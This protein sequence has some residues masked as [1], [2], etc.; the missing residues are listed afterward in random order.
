MAKLDADNPFSRRSIGKITTNEGYNNSVI[1]AAQMNI[2]IMNSPYRSPFISSILVGG[3]TNLK[4]IFSSHNLHAY[5]GLVMEKYMLEVVV[6]RVYVHVHKANYISD[7]RP[8]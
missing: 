3:I 6:I 7:S 4:P 1:H 8:S 5:F 2:I